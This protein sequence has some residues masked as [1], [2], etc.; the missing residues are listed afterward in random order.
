MHQR[1]DDLL[2]TTTAASTKSRLNAVAVRK[3]GEDVSAHLAN[4]RRWRD[5]RGLAMPAT[6][7]KGDLFSTEGLRAYALGSNARGSMDRGVAV[8]FKKRWPKLATELST[9]AAKGGLALGDVVVFS[10]GDKTVYSLIL[11]EDEDR[12]TDRSHPRG[13]RAVRACVGV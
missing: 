4:Y 10:E 5:T 7:A 3:R 6:F 2:A 9:R 1:P 12:R 11:Q 8:A 13:V